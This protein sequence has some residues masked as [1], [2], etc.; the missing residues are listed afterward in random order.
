MFPSLLC[1]PAREAEPQPHPRKCWETHT[2]LRVR[3]RPRE[4]ISSNACRGSTSSLLLSIS[5][6]IYQTPR[7]ILTEDILTEDKRETSFA[8][9]GTSQP[10]TR[11]PQAHVRQCRL[12]VHLADTVARQGLDAATQTQ[13]ELLHAGA[14]RGLRYSKC[15][16]RYCWLGS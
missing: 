16:P 1:E 4:R 5:K 10:R 12:H 6:L 14:R 11:R 8:F 2:A 9:K 3:P 15:S 7:G 13:R